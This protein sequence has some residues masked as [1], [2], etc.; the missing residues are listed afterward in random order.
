MHPDED[1]STI[2][3][4][5]AQRG[6]VAREAWALAAAAGLPATLRMRRQPSFG[7]IGQKFMR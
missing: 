7:G 4:E 2:M 3:E 5:T 1:A 6:K